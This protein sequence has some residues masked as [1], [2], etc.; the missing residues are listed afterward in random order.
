MKK[1]TANQKRFL[2]EYK[3][4]LCLSN[5]LFEISIGTLLGYASIQ[6]QNQGKSYR[7]KFQQSNK[8][9]RDYLHHLHDQ[10]SDWVLSAPHYDKKRNMWSFQTISHIDFNKLADIFV[11]DSQKNLCKKHIKPYFVEQYL[12]PRALAYWIMDDGGKSS[13]NKDYQRKGFAL[14]THSFPKNQ[15]EILR[16]GLETRYG[17]N[18]WL[19]SNKNKWIIVISGN[20]HKKMMDLIS[21]FIIPSMYH[22]IPGLTE[23]MT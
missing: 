16:Q 19:K 7:L 17:L 20:D 1:P 6:T 8:L 14:N 11:L 12:T 21:E 13:Y 22:K 15:V 9:H 5:I 3:Q 2:I 10:F 4:A 23:L 18:C